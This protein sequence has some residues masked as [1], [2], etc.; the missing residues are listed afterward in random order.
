MKTAA[1]PPREGMSAGGHQGAGMRT[2]RGSTA[3]RATALLAALAIAALVFALRFNTL[4]GSL[5]GF[6]ND[7]Y[8]HLL[9]TDMLLNGE[10]PLRD[11]AEAELRGAWPSLGYAVSAWAQQLWGATLLSEA[12]LTV[13][14]LALATAVVFLVALDVSQRWL[15][16]LLATACVI[17]A[18]PKLYN[19]EKVLMLAVA[20]GLARLWIVRPST[21]GL[22]LLAVWTAVATL[23]RHDFGVYVALTAVA[24]I[25]VRG[26]GPWTAVARRLALYVAVTTVLLLPSIVWV[27]V[28]AGVV[29][30]VQATLENVKGESARTDLAWPT[31]DPEQGFDERNLVSLAY[32]AFWG[33]PLVAVCLLAW[34][35]A[36]RMPFITARRLR[37]FT[38]DRTNADRDRIDLATG[39]TLAALAIAV[40]TSFLRGALLSRFGD[41]IAPVALLAAWATAVVPALP[42]VH[43][44]LTG[45]AWAAPR[46]LLLTILSAVFMAGDTRPE[47]AASGLTDSWEFVQLRFHTAR[48]E[49]ARQPPTTWSDV[50]P[51]GTLVAARYVAECTRPTDRV[52]LLTYAPE[53]PVYARR[54]FAAAQGTFGLNFYTWEEQQR[55]A[56]ARLGEQSVPIVIGSYDDFEGEIVDDYPLMAKYVAEHYR[57]AGAIAVD[58]EPRFRVFVE[59]DRQPQ[60]VD[61]TLGLP[62]YR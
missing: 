61:S 45:V 5:G 21:S 56:V 33:V 29:P 12:Y 16:A 51:E 55:N 49:L 46:V 7:H 27:Q 48:A 10:Q 37:A 58:G 22:A 52:L 26:P 30:Y 32:Y 23:F 14:G 19:Y 43:T 25:L 15:V 38:P 39:V 4:G 36:V 20:A 42:Q 31:F 3:Q 1:V 8:V 18:G 34:R 47:L 62:C 6:D 44:V 41:A 57:E 53:I 59:R 35:V 9:R 40:N 17:A 13:G 2:R 50:K 11:F 28:Y 60:G 24:A 54:R